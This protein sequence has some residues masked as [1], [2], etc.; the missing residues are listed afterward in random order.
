MRLYEL[1]E[2]IKEPIFLLLRLSVLAFSVVF[3]IKKRVY[4]TQLM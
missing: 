2:G 3:Y 4:S 1:I